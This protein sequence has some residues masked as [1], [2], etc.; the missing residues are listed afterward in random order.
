M[1]DLVPTY[2]EGTGQVS[3]E[4]AGQLLA[5]LHS[6][7]IRDAVLMGFCRFGMAPPHDVSE[8]LAIGFVPELAAVDNLSSE[9]SDGPDGSDGSDGSADP[10]QGE[11]ASATD[12]AVERLLVDLC[13]RVDGPLACAPLTMLAWHS[14]ARGD[15]ATARVAVE[16]ALGEDPTYRL[17]T[18]L[19]SVL[20]HA[21]APEWVRAVR[22][23]DERAS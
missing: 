17:A 14:W 15:G 19:L 5:S 11:L 18:L 9:G 4:Q 21:V 3:V 23:A 22:R 13:Q 7:D 2:R 20:D 1:A 8:L 12:D 16:R 10:D 6:R